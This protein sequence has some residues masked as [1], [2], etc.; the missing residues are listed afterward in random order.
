M[1]VTQ[2]A[3]TET[4]G[5][6][7][8]G[9]AADGA[10]L[11]MVFGEGRRLADGE[12]LASLRARYPGAI[13]FGCSTSGEIA[14]TRVHDGT[15]VATAVSFARTRVRLAET[16]LAGEADSAP[17]G[18]RLAEALRRSGLTHVLVLSDGLGVNGSQLAAGLSGV[19]GD[20]ICVS[21]GLAGDGTDFKRT[22]VVAG[23]TVGSSM[24]AA[25][26]FY[27]D[28]LTVRCASLGGWDPFGPERVVTRADGHVL[29][30]LDGQSALGLYKRYLGP[31]ADG[32]PASALLFPLAV[33]E[34]GKE[35]VV[36]TVLAVDDEA[37]SMTFAGDVPEGA[38]ARLMK[39]NFDRLI[40]GATGAA[41][42][43][44]TGGIAPGAGLALLISCVGRRLVLRQRT[45]EEV[46]AVREVLGEEPVLTGFYSYG[47]ISPFTAGGPCRL[48]NQTM[49]ITAFTETRDH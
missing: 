16:A 45:E 36:R 22:L 40:D 26:G 2:Q 6:S 18:R 14:D 5:W 7:G 43:C 17:A 19:L 46:E 38:H 9:C 13:L 47:E 3:W 32:L 28:A 34:P 39:A 8:A 37:A 29:Y 4:G 27:G 48:H 20:G 35:A 10:H 33:R 21:G 42:E 44:H 24:A 49:T 23:D 31:H 30:E 12:V 25:V 41:R 1:R 15:V 11:V